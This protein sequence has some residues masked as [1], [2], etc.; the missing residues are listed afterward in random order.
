[1][2]GGDVVCKRAPLLFP[3]DEGTPLFRTFRISGDELPHCGR[4]GGS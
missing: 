4:R 3:E 1:M 2:R